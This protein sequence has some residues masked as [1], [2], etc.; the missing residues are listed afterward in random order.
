MLVSY[1]KMLHDVDLL[2][3]PDRIY[4]LV[5]WKIL[6]VSTLSSSRCILPA[7]RSGRFEAKS[8]IAPESEVP[9]PLLERYVIHGIRGIRN[10]EFG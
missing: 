3:A 4:T 1:S 9:V 10:F 2:M 8:T 5:C 6:S 7:I